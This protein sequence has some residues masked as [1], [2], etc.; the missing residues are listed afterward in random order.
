MAKLDSLD[1]QYL[2]EGF[3]STLLTPFVTLTVNKSESHLLLKNLY[4]D[5]LL[6]CRKFRRELINANRASR[7]WQNYR[8]PC[9]EP[10]Y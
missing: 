3:C 1:D 4:S 6:D 2:K 5:R 9:P 10:R 7:M 8:L